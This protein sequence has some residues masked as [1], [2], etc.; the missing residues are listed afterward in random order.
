MRQAGHAAEL[1][2]IIIAWSNNPAAHPRRTAII[3]TSDTAVDQAMTD[4]GWIEPQIIASAFQSHFRLVA[5]PYPSLL[6]QILLILQVTTREEI[7]QGC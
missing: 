5:I 2:S 3:A 4:L 1:S 6:I 7:C